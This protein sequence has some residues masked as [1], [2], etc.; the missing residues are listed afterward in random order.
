[1][2][3]DIL[4]SFATIFALAASLRVG[5]ANAQNA[6]DTLKKIKQTGQITLGAGESSGLATL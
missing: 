4:C 5:S 2:K 6:S 1:M 3:Q